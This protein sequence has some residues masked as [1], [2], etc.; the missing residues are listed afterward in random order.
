[1]KT[2]TTTTTTDPTALLNKDSWITQ[3]TALFADHEWPEGTQLS[4]CAMIKNG[5]KKF[6]KPFFVDI[7][8]CDAAWKILSKYAVT[9][10]TYFCVS[11]LESGIT[12]GRGKPENVVGLSTLFLDIDGDWGSH[13]AEVLPTR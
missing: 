9:T 13:S 6:L 8:D 4:I 10:D 7:Y 2:T 3:H 11:G 5:G 1:M 12:S